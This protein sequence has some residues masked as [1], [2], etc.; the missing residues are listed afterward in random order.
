MLKTQGVA[1]GHSALILALVAF[2]AWKFLP[3]RSQAAPVRLRIGAAV[4]MVAALAIA[5]KLFGPAMRVEP[6]GLK[7]SSPA[8]NGFALGGLLAIWLIHRKLFAHTPDG[9][10]GLLGS[11]RFGS[12]ADVIGLA[13]NDGDL[14]IG[15]SHNSGKVLH[16][17][18]P[19]HLLTIA[20]T[21]S[22]KGV[23]TIIP[24]LLAAN[25]SIICIDPKGENARVTGRR[26]ETFGPVHYLDPFGLS[27]HPT[28]SWNPLA[29]LDP[30][31]LDLAED[32][33][34]PADALVFDE[35]CAGDPHW[36]EDAKALIAGIILHTVCDPDLHRRTLGT[37]RD[38][39]T[40]AP[41]A[42]S[43]L[44]AAMQA[45][46]AARGLVARAA[47]RHLAKSDREAASILSSAQRHTIS[48]TARASPPRPIAAISGSRTS[49]PASAPC[50]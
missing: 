30:D 16:Y 11:A 36:N 38:G 31:S 24:N 34:T 3:A 20:P 43:A 5:L 47:N 45:S 23:G 9:S 17:D 2:A 19:A 22:G 26:R 14:I 50:S 6:N 33:M 40:L 13:R 25:R 15:R 28:A 4:G 37:V 7:S 1:W 12:R 44:L 29:T 18:G 8:G 32:A 35:A 49:R 48:S 10:A 41:D 39:L 27:G 21:R 46:M 42:F